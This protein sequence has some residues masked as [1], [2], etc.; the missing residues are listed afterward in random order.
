MHPAIKRAW[1]LNDLFP[2]IPVATGGMLALVGHKELATPMV[3]ILVGLFWGLIGRFTSRVITGLAVV[4]IIVGIGSIYLTTLA[5]QNLW[6][7]LLVF[8]GISCLV[9]GIM[10]RAQQ[11]ETAS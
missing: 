2:I 8:Q 1:G 5:I 7:Y 4:N 3:L 11:H 9:A 6:M 10:L